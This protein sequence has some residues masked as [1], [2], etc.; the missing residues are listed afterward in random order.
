MALPGPVPAVARQAALRLAE[1][2]ERLVAELNHAQ[3]RLLNTCASLTAGL[4]PEALREIYGP[5]GADL[6][7]SGRKP[8]TLDDPHPHEALERAS[9]HIREAFDDDQRLADER[10]VLGVDVGEA[11][12]LLVDALVAAGWIE[13]ARAADVMELARDEPGPTRH[14][15]DERGH[16]PELADQAQCRPSPCVTMSRTCAVSRRS[17]SLKRVD[18][19]RRLAWVGIAS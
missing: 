10:R 8:P 1:R 16:R 13:Q 11:N 18:G 5:S 6:G 7:L 3:D 14:P 9:Q 12:A 4:S 15:C 17:M 2:D 19:S